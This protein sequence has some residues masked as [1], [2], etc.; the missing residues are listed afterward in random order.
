MDH[1]ISQASL[2]R[3]DRD[4]R[5]GIDPR[6][7]SKLRYGDHQRLSFKRLCSSAGIGSTVRIGQPV[8]KVYQREE[9][10]QDDG[11]Q[12]SEPY[13][14]GTP[15]LARGYFA[16]TSG[17]VTDEVIIKYIDEQDAE[18]SDTEFQIEGQVDKAS[19]L[20]QSYCLRAIVVYFL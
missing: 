17:N 10:S 8:G 15:H 18:S 11:I 19:S 1:E 12:D 3:R 9:F 13:I 20:C 5:L 14:L 7:L 16:A 6:D 4:T 2:A